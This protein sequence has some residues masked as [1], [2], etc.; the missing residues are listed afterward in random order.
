[1]P[2][3]RT[4]AIFAALLLAP[5]LA[6]AALPRMVTLAEAQEALALP[7]VE[8]TT[9][10]VTIF[11]GTNSV[12]FRPGFRRTAVNGVAVWLN[13]PAEPDYKTTLRLARA[14]LDRLLVPILAA[15]CGADGAAPSQ[16]H[17]VAT[18]LSSDWS[19]RRAA[20][21]AAEGG[22]IFLDPGHGGEDCGAVS[23]ATGQQEKDLVLDVALRIGAILEDAGLPVAY[24]R[25]NDTFVTL[26]GRADMATKNNATLFVS[27]HAN[28]TGN[29]SARGIETFSLSL[30]GCDSTS[31]DSRISKKEWPGNA[32]DAESAVLGYLVQAAVNTERGE[33]DRGLRHARFQVLREAPCPAVLV[34]CGFLSNEAENTSLESP[35]YRQ[36]VAAAIA[37][38]ILA[39]IGN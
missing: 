28:T 35:R 30:A 16:A 15:A 14:D 4:N 17:S 34:E 19:A 7:M 2:H 23:A 13:E 24:S 22:P 26:P 8:T 12:A 1:M 38:G 9:D 39:Y 31:G 3:P 37:S 36:R 32:F 6:T 25:T 33:A 18:R 27:V 5:V 29:A 11:D 20:S 21:H 10:L